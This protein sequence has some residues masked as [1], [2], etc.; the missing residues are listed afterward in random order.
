MLNDEKGKA[1]KAEV[2]F[3]V[4]N[5]VD[6]DPKN[7]IPFQTSGDSFYYL[8][9]GQ[10]YIP[11]LG[12]DDNLPSLLL[13]ARLLSP[14]QNACIQS[15]AKT[16]IG[17]GLTI[18]ET[19]K[20]NGEWLQWARSVNNNNQSLDEVLTGIVEGER[21]QG[22]QFIEIVKGSIGKTKYV[23]IYLHSDLYCRLEAPENSSDTPKI[24]LIS[25]SFAKKGKVGDIS[26]AKRIPLWSPNPL[27]Q[28][29]CWVKEGDEQR[30]MLHFK[31]EVAGVD[32][33]GLPASIAGIRYQLLES[34]S[35]QYNLDNFDNNMIIGGML[36]FKSAMTNEEAQK[37]AKE[38]LLTHVGEGKTGRVV[39][40]ASEMGI[41]GVDFKPF[42]T[43]KE[44]SFIEFDKRVESKI[45]AANGWDAMLAGI[46]RP[47]GLASGNQMI[48]SVFDTK[49]AM[50]C[51]PLR[52]RLVDKVVNPIA[53]IWSEHF[54]ASEVTKYKFD[55]KSAM[56]YSYLADLDP[57]KFMT[58]D[59]ARK[60]AGLDPLGLDK[61]GDKLLSE[62]KSSKNVQGQ[63]AS[64]QGANNT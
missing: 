20:P 41:D 11:F 6:L 7:P 8:A 39:V 53:K 29:S 50:L 26:K 47:S 55:F 4:Q 59:E 57:D 22:N 10:K 12:K 2:R 3:T 34:K 37:Q 24:V 27:D 61:G 5:T 45:V 16:T 36:I 48:R 62:I 54:G 28:N 19:E 32:H 30:T 44:G 18:L 35:A 40:L 25:K 23:K 14:T 52:L 1:P 63:P 13:E 42:E 43:Q 33:Y 64:A 15:I 31:N 49:E 9:R 46:E 21:G 51:K 56:P 38:I 58:V 17:A 60:L